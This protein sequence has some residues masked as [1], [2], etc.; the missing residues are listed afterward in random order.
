[1]NAVIVLDVPE[2]QIGQEATVYFPD[3]MQKKAVCERL[4]EAEPMVEDEHG[5]YCPKCKL[6][7]IGK[8]ASGY[9]C[10]I[11]DLPE[12]EVVSFCPMCGRAVKWE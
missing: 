4:Q 7:L 8:T 11:F 12:D 2:W 9:P 3:T 1:M 10:G 5:W 6:K